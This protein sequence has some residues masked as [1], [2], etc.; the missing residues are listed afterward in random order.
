MHTDNPSLR[1]A[2]GDSPLGLFAVAASDA[3]IAAVIFGETREELVAELRR[4]FAAAPREDQAGLAATIARI[5]ALIANPGKPVD[6]PL[7]PHGTAFQRQV[8]EVLRQIPAGRTLSY[9]EVA[10][11]I[12][13]PSAMRAVAQ[14]CGA[15][16][17]A[18]AIPCHRVVRSDG[19]AGGYRWGAARKAM[20]L[21]AEAAL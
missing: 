5:T 9:G 12:G 6:L 16:P 11:R 18:V 1:F 8:W 7:D 17:I 14:A 3:G 4:R 2:I 10:S 13:A 15:N 19:S 20:L 21:R